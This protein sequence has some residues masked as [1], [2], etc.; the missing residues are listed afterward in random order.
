MCRKLFEF[1]N[2]HRVH[3]RILPLWSALQESG[4]IKYGL[5]TSFNHI[6]SKNK[7]MYFGCN[8]IEILHVNQRVSFWIVIFVKT[9]RREKSVKLLLFFFKNSLDYLHLFIRSPEHC[10]PDHFY[11]K[12]WRKRLISVRERLFFLLDRKMVR[13][14]FVNS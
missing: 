5:L 3:T 7:T 4:E 2:Q 8:L 6:H 13:F 12:S 9:P 11:W 14:I 10:S 1:I